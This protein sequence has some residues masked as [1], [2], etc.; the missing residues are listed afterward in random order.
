MRSHW[1]WR[2]TVAVIASLLAVLLSAPLGGPAAADRHESGNPDCWWGNPWYDWEV[3][4]EP[5]GAPDGDQVGTL[6]L[7]WNIDTQ[8]IRARADVDPSLVDQFQF[9]TVTLEARGNHL[10]CAS[11]QGACETDEIYVQG[12]RT[13]AAATVVTRNGGFT[14]TAE[15]R[16]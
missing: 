10:F 6:G 3:V 5:I 1:S 9:L 11:R 8:C 4:T 7:I 13:L 2:V 14:T 15:I 16:I 12:Q